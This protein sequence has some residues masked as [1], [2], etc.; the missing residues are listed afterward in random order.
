VNNDVL[1]TM[2]KPMIAVFIRT[3]LVSRFWFLVPRFWG[4]SERDFD[5]CQNLLQYSLADFRAAL[6]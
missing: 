3:F 4:R 5:Q 6:G 1:P 2:G